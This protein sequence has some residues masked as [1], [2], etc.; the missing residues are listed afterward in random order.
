MQ[1][2]F[3][4]HN[5]YVYILREHDEKSIKLFGNKSKE[6]LICFPGTTKNV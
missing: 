3:S 1:R 2:I 4:E 5:L 6:Y